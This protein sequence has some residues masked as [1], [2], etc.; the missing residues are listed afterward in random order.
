MG[1][2]LIG[3]DREFFFS[4]GDEGESPRKTFED[5]DGISFSAISSQKLLK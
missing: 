1:I 5:R 4:C 2:V 3:K